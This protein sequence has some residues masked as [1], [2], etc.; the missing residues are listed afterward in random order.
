MEVTKVT[1]VGAG[2]HS[3]NSMQEMERALNHLAITVGADRDI[4]TNLVKEVEQP[5]KNNVPL[6]TQLSDVI[7]I[8][9]EMAKKINLKATQEQNPKFNILAEKVKI[10]ASFERN[11]DPEG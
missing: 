4:V 7:N 10:K 8:N 3:A 5:T 11:L 1:T 9:L 2:F 6:M